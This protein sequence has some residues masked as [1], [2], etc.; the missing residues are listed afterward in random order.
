MAKIVDDRTQIDQTI[1]IFDSF[2]SV[3]LVVSADQY[4]IV[5]GFFLGICPSKKIANNFTAILFR[6]AQETKIDILEL[7]QILKGA[8]NKLK[9]NQIFAYYANSLKSKTSLYGIAN[10]PKPNVPVAR[11]IVQ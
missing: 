6:I 1:K 10:V 11:N 7:V 8:E 9:M 2:Y 5:H 3:R 4:D